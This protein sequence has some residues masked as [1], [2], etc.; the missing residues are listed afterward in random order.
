MRKILGSA[1]MNFVIAGSVIAAT[2]DT[3]KNF[4]IYKAPEFPVAEWR[5]PKSKCKRNRR[6]ERGW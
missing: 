5:R 6:M 1:L 4:K 3:V 2:D